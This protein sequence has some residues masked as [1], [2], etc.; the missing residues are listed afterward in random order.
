MHYFVAFDLGSLPFPVN[1]RDR[2]AVNESHHITASPFKTTKSYVTHDA[3]SHNY[4]HQSTVLRRSHPARFHLN[5][6]LHSQYIYQTHQHRHQCMNQV[7]QSN[8]Q[9]S[10][11]LLLGLMHDYINLLDITLKFGNFQLRSTTYID[12]IRC[13]SNSLITDAMLT[14]SWQDNETP[15]CSVWCVLGHVSSAIEIQRYVGV[16]RLFFVFS[17]PTS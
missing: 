15:A 9:P 12:S 1:P 16:T 6:K 10:T 8:Q 3:T 7:T 11:Y 14:P 17:T 13:V 5:A 2:M 4:I